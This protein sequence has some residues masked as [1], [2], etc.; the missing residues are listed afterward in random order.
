MFKNPPSG[1]P[2]EVESYVVVS[3]TTIN[4][5]DYVTLT[6]TRAG[7]ANRAASRVLTGYGLRVSVFGSMKGT[8][9]LSGA[10]R[11]TPILPTNLSICPSLGSF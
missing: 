5:Q 8:A 1:A 7:V 9:A 4:A 2:A 10:S 3:G 6:S 11:T